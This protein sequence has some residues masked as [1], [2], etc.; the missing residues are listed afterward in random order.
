MKFIFIKGFYILLFTMAFTSHAQVI[1][2]G[3][4]GNSTVNLLARLDKDVLEKSPDLVIL[5]IGTND[6]LNAKKMLSYAEYES[7]LKQII[8]KIKNTGAK[9]VVMAPPP[10][11]SIYLFERH[12]RKKFDEVPNKKMETI[13][14]IVKELATTNDLGFIDL[15]A[16][17]SQMNLP[18]HD[19]DLFFRSKMNSNARDGVHPTALGYYFIGQTVYH[20]LKTNSLLSKDQK[21]ICFGDSI[22]YGSGAQGGGTAEGDC[23]PCVLSNLITK[24]NIAKKE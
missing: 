20:Y 3:V 17:F 11:D 7:N 13:R 12:D 15:F 18:K 24:K 9:I 2:A 5:M 21:I 23:Y 16:Q 22:T 1:N 6:M 14:N 10:V 4:S 19:E 8:G